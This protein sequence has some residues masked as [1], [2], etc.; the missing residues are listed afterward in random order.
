MLEKIKKI[1]PL[2]VLLLVGMMIFST[3]CIYSATIHTKYEGTHIS[4]LRNYA[5]GFVCFF[6]MA[7]FDYRILMR[8]SWYLY[9]VCILL[10]AGIFKFG[11]ELNGAVG[12]YKLP[13]GF[14]F[15]PAELAKFA[16]VIV[17]TSFLYRRRG[18][19]LSLGR[20]VIPIGLIVLLPFTLVLV[21]PDLGNA[22]IYLVI[23]TAM[24]WIG[25]IR[26]LQALIAAA[27]IGAA[28]FLFISTFDN[29]KDAYANFLQ[30]TIGK[31]HWVTRIATFLNP[32]AA[33]ESESYHVNNVYRAIGSGQLTGEGFLSGTS[34]HKDFIPYVYADSIVV[35]VGEEFGFVGMSLMLLAYFLLIYRMVLIAIQSYDLRGAY[36]TVGIVSLLVFQIFL[37]VAMHLK[38]MP[39]TGITLPFISY[40]GTSLL[41]NMASLG[42]VV[43]VRIH[44]EKPLPYATE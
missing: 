33:S 14:S 26:G 39:F 30:E 17:L 5:I 16:L 32:D 22:M 21:Q 34:V 23:M 4:N 3:L 27:V 36:M 6:A 37:N 12:W 9:G 18:E 35:L 40:G 7:L 44:Q 13:M 28:G 43:S 1:D 41:I 10:L 24:L 20:D 2:I 15:Q 25:N 31:G 29:M 8:I 11:S 19:Y 42:M 38:M